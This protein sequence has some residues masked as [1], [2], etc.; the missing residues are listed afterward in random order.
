[1][2]SRRGQKRRGLLWCQG[3]WR[4]MR[5]CRLRWVSLQALGIGQSRGAGRPYRGPLNRHAHACSPHNH[6]PQ[7]GQALPFYRDI[8]DNGFALWHCLMPASAGDCG[9]RR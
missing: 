5:C 3:K 7:S 8:P 4:G 2:V 1:M 6:V 9:G